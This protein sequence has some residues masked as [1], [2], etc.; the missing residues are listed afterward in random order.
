MGFSVISELVLYLPLQNLGL[1][2][3]CSLTLKNLLEDPD[4]VRVKFMTGDY[5]FLPSD[6]S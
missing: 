4:H 5:L 3:S 2:L 1:S 6:S